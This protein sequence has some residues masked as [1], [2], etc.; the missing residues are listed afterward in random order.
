MSK[1]EENKKIFKLVVGYY[2]F[3][4]LALILHYSF[5]KY[6]YIL[7]EDDFI[8]ELQKIGYDNKDIAKLQYDKIQNDIFNYSNQNLS[9]NE[10]M[11]KRKYIRIYIGRSA[12]GNRRYT[13]RWQ[14]FEEWKYEAEKKLREKYINKLSKNDRT[15]I[16]LFKRSNYTY[17][18][19][20]YKRNLYGGIGFILPFFL[21][22][23]NN[24]PLI[25]YI[26]AL[27]IEVAAH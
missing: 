19:Y 5:N 18:D 8:K 27:M 7:D 25:I 4:I 23:V 16:K 20:A 15:L 21:I 3:L 9:N 22:P 2:I 11:E 10:Y 26:F 1:E 13:T 17:D 14:T 24:A 12:L 6:F